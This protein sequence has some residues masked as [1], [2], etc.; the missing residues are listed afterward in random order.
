M[1]NGNPN[2]AQWKPDG[3][4]PLPPAPSEFARLLAQSRVVPSAHGSRAVAE[5]IQ[6]QIQICVSVAVGSSLTSQRS[7]LRINPVY[8]NCWPSQIADRDPNTLEKGAGRR[9]GGFRRCGLAGRAASTTIHVS[10]ARVA[11]KKQHTAAIQA[12]V[13]G[14][15][16]GVSGHKCPCGPTAT[17]TNTSWAAVRRALLMLV[18]EPWPRWSRSA[19]TMHSWYC[20]HDCRPSRAA[21][22]VPLEPERAPSAGAGATAEAVV[23]SPSP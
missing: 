7:A 21:S 16:S 1:R 15:F 8:A 12:G 3:Q 5:Q 4:S 22:S 18:V 14:R 9:T 6:I 2:S 19:T 10:V 17:A 13:A 23:A 20:P 11:N